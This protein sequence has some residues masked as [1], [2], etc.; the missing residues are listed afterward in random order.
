MISDVI[1]KL[2]SYLSFWFPNKDISKKKDLLLRKEILKK[3]SNIKIKNKNLKKT[4]IDFNNRI[5]SLLKNHNLKNFLR[6]SFI[7]K[8]FFLHNR[9]FVFKE[10]K[11]IQ[12]SKN[13]GF[14]EKILKEDSVGNP[15]RYFLYLK[16]SGNRINH[17]YHLYKLTTKTGINFKKNIRNIFEFGSG[18]GCMPRIF[19]KINRNIK[20][21]SFDTA[22]VNLLQYYYLKHN[23][24]D[25]GFSKKNQFYLTS[26]LSGKIKSNDLFIANWSLSET[27]IFFRE[28][29]FKVIN[30][31]R[32]IL[33][34]FQEYFEDIN[35]LK[36]FN[37]LKKRLNNSFEIRIEK[38]EYY[39]G[40]IFNNQNHYFL[41]GKKLKSDFR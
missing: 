27:P 22:Y 37:K 12:K 41:I 13:W 16:S 34:S 5:L 35:N 10:L 21:T 9:F 19:S 40:N 24:L 17:V 15:I 14:Y 39:K 6:N 11:E 7:Q 31:S 28:K 30:R 4:H 38:N 29:F 25:A 26:N 33:I 36:Y 18:Y 3:L 1:R 23:N 32:Y 20:Y 8:M 2:L